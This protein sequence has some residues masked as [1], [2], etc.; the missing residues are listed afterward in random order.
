M[1]LS[2]LLHSRATTILNKYFTHST[3]YYIYVSDLV[4]PWPFSQEQVCDL[5]Q[6]LHASDQSDLLQNFESIIL[7]VLKDVR[8]YQL[9]NER[10][11][12]SF[13]RWLWKLDLAKTLFRL[14]L[15][16]YI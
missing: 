9:E 10:L 11:E 8:F 2:V 1:N 13:K 3:C 7:G 14:L 6:Q 4:C 16:L 5:Y 12:K 15:H